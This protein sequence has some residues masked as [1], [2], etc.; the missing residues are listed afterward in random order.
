MGSVTR[1]RARLALTDLFRAECCSLGFPSGRND[2]ENTAEPPAASPW[3]PAPG[4]AGR[5]AK[6]M[7]SST[8]AASGGVF[9]A[10]S[11]QPSYSIDFALNEWLNY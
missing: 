9:L 8:Q 2:G 11:S 6:G 5:D 4:P 3:L 7:L 1:R 10:N